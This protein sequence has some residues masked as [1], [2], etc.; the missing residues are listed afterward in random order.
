MVV[1]GLVGAEGNLLMET[2]EKGVLYVYCVET[3]IIDLGYHFSVVKVIQLH[4][5]ATNAH[6]HH[7]QASLRQD[8]S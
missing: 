3:V 6:I 5:R 2:A 8:S 4:F 1:E 7:P